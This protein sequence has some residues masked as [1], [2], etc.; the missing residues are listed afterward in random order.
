MTSNPLF[1]Q[2]LLV[3]LVLIGLL[4]YGG[5]P[6]N[7]STTAK[8]ALQPDKPRRQRA[9]DPKPCPGLLHNPLC[10][11]CAQGADAP[12]QAPGAPPPVLT[13]TRGR[14]RPGDTAPHCCPEHDGV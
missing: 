3:A 7:P 2:L 9:K 4:I 11:A 6:A 13:C 5:W 8:T 12:P 10:D 14:P 1:Y